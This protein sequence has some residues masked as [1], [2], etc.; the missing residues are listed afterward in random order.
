MTQ[1]SILAGARYFLFSGK[2]QTCC[3][4]HPNFCSVGTG[5]SFHGG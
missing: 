5:C 4:A 3:G 2:D 1:G